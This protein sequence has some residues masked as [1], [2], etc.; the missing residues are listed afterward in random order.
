M[1]KVQ[2]RRERQAHIFE[3]HFRASSNLGAAEAGDEGS[4]VISDDPHLA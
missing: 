1:R 4:D 2:R 3:D